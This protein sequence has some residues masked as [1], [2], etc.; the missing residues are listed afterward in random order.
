MVKKIFKYSQIIDKILK[1][2]DTITEPIASTISPKGAN[3]IYE[4]EQGNQHITN[5][6]VT[7]AKHISVKDEVENA[8]IEIIKG[9]ALKT[10]MEAGDGTSSTVL[11]S[12]V[13]IKEGLRLISGGMNQMKVRDELIKFAEDMKKELSKSVKKVKTDNDLKLIAQI[14]ANNDEKIANDIVK[15][16]KVVGEDGQV[17]L[18]K[19]FTNETEIIEDTGFTVNGGVFAPELANKQLQ[20]GMIDVPV[21]VTDKRIYYK[22]EAETILSTAM[23]AGYSQVVIVAQDFIG[24]ALPFFITN[25]INNK[26]KVML[27]IEKNYETL[28]DIALYLGTEVVSD[29]K[30]SLVDKITID[31]FAMAKRVFSNQIK[32]IISRDKSEKNK[33]L[34]KRIKVLK[35]E[36][37]KLGNK[38]DPS[39]TKLQKRISSLTCGMV[40]V[41]VG[42]ATHLEI[43]EKIFRYE[44]A[45]N[46]ARAALKEGWL[47]GAGIS[48]FNAFKKIKINKDCERMF[49]LAS[50]INIRQ[51]AENCGKSPDVILNHII[52]SKDVNIGYNAATDKFE[53]IIRAGIIEPF[54][55]T[56]QVILNAVS[57]AN[58]II[59]SKY[60]VVND[61]DALKDNK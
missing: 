17:M 56:S 28:E 46:A 33:S 51:I 8:I 29:K 13:L 43:I 21:L 10:N 42:G 52:N 30:G 24:E 4:D 12:S 47:P 60:L 6:G 1:A 16:I 7:I 23:K 58:I 25:H 22:S 48:V 26:I 61:I 27:I 32:S 40:T 36:L 9:G 59:T 39:Y 15:I 18:D 49:K 35:S 38:N 53:D 44:D 50:E 20:V 37:K 55:V 2:V 45:V 54:L 3:V 34:E 19:G 5:D 57:I 14:S 41:K 31:N 11:M